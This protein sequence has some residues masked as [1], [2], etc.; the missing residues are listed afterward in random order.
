MGEQ[1]KVGSKT[2][3]K[4]NSKMVFGQSAEVLLAYLGVVWMERL[5]SWALAVFFEVDPVLHFRGLQT[6]QEGWTG[7][8]VFGVYLLPPVLLALFGVTVIET[9]KWWMKWEALP[10]SLVFWVGALASSRALLGGAVGAFSSSELG[11]VYTWAF[12]PKAAQYVL[13]TLSFG[14]FAL[15]LTRIR[16]P[17]LAMSPFK[18]GV[19]DD[20][21]RNRYTWSAFTVPAL[22]PLAFSGFITLEFG[23]YNELYFGL[24]WAILGLIL[25]RLNDLSTPQY[26]FIRRFHQKLGWKT[27]TWLLASVGAV[28]SIWYR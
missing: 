19:K 3:T 24:L 11:Y 12:V 25:L 5:A 9:W 22:V 2:T 8:A 16:L 23:K 15:F 21:L 28:L 13:A 10:R 6:G 7:D 4:V 26:H 17:F 14:A 18:R 1:K 20:Y 27:T